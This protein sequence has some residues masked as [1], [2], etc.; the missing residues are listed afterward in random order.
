MA[1]ART[2]MAELMPVDATAIG[3]LGDAQI[4]ALDQYIYRFNKW[5][6]TLGARAFDHALRLLAEDADSMA[7]IDKLN[8]LEKLGAL[9]SAARWLELRALRNTL[10]H[11]YSDNADE[12]AQALNALF[13]AYS[14]IQQMTATFDDRISAYLEGT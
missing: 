12:L 1:F 9:P 10:A 7:F 13:D 8:R 11:E 5:Q 2:K 4:A 14:E 3:A 6:D